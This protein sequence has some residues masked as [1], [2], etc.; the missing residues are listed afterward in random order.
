MQ[1][2]RMWHIK[3][4]VHSFVSYSSEMMFNRAR[5]FNCLVDTLRST[6]QLN[7][8]TGPVNSGKTLLVE[9]VLTHVEAENGKK[10][11]VYPINLWRGTFHS[12][13][14]FVKSLSTGMRSWVKDILRSVSLSASAKGASL[15]YEWT[16]VE[17][18]NQLTN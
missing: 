7:I 5:E 1:C 8:I 6:P 13:E 16:L 10:T 18:Q 17:W 12:V 9:K 2:H 3:N 15:A 14:S 11:P 4:V